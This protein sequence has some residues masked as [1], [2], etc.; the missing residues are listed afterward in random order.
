MSGADADW[1]IRV[2]GISKKFGLT[3]RQSMKYGLRDMAQ[4]LVG[5]SGATGDLREGEFWA[6]NNVSFEVRRGEALGIM[7]VNGCGKTT[8][9]RILNGVYMPDRGRA[10]LRGRVG[11]MIAAGAGFAPMLSGRENI[12]VNGALL[13]LSTREVDDL[14]DEIIAF[15]ELGHLIDLPVKNYSSGMY[16]R[17]GFAI[18]ALSRPDV[19]LMDEVLAVGD[20]NFQKKCFDYILKLKRSGTA[21]ILVSHSPGAIW[22]VCDRGVFMN[23]GS[24]EVNGSVEDAIRAYDDQNSRNAAVASAELE[25]IAAVNGNPATP[26]IPAEY[27]HSKGGTGDVV[28]TSVRVLNSALATTGNE[29]EFAEPIVIEAEFTVER[30]VDELLLRFTVDAAHYRFIATLDSYEQGL[31]LPSVAPGKY[32][33]NVHVKAPNF[34]PGCY[35]LNV[36]VSQKRVGVH[37]FYWFGAS[38]F[39]VKHPASMFLYADNNA[40]MHLDSDF[41]LARVS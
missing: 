39:V 27:G 22:S 6:V 41:S 31:E 37:L 11:A 2:D 38:H 7:G 40:V 29:F 5:R 35:T 23:R 24:V 18:A 26:G 8:L 25:K 17:L 1:A 33:L 36:G 32:R 9:L 14:M 16:V 3:L 13:G 4:R 12:Y 21:I 19:L 20:L 34:R 10:S 28:C 15:S 30:S